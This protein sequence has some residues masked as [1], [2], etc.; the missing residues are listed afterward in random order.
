M[1]KVR[2]EREKN[3]FGRRY[4]RNFDMLS[5]E[6]MESVRRAK[7][8]VVGCGGLGGH[9]IEQLARLGVGKLTVIDGDV[10]DETN[11]NRQLLSTVEALGTS[12][13][14]AAKDRVAKINPETV[15][16]TRAERLA[17]ANCE[18]ILA[19]HHVVVDAVD[20]VDTRMLLQEF[21]EKLD[22]PLVHGAIAGWY[23]QVGTVFPGDRTLSK[24]YGSGE[25]HGI[26]RELGNP[27]FTPGLVASLQV[28]EVLKVIVGRGELLRKRILYIDLFEHEYVL[29]NFD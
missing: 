4:D 1:E 9:I 2:T 27:S 22:I 29:M 5:V 23:G 19:G 18:E 10:F 7:V 8:C 17:S 13:S 25:K 6:D 11:L 14:Q 24:I 21:C 3:P 16:Q 26:E 15:V 28:S 20:N 12:K